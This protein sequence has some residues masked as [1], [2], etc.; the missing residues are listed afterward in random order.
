MDRRQFLAAAGLALTVPAAGCS[1]PDD[2]TEPPDPQRVTVTFTNDGARTIVFTAAAMAEGLGGVELT[3]ADS[4]TETLSDA[5]T[6]DEVPVEAWER[7]VTFT[8]LGDAQRREFRSTG[9]S[10][11]EIEF[12]PTPYGTTVVTTLVDP[13]ADPPMQATGAG[14]CDRAEGAAIRVAVDPDG[15][16]HQSTICTDTG[17][18]S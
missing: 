1:A 17:T 15:L 18:P 7:A 10:G 12:E 5:E 8:P 6:V 11:V 4:G 2:G 9:R 13:N 3:D 16:V 14:T